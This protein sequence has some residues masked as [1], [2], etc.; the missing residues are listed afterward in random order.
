MAG[1]GVAA[2]VAEM[3]IWKTGT[4]N[5]PQIGQ[6]PSSDIDCMP[7]QDEQG[8]LQ[9]SSWPEALAA[10]RSRLAGLHGDQIRAIAGKLADAESMIAMKVGCTLPSS[11]L[12]KRDLGEC[13]VFF[14]SFLGLGAL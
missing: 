5:V 3:Y 10:V 13:I 14:I 4:Q 9:N 12:V 11:F 8:N 2:R 7:L 1:I 6:E